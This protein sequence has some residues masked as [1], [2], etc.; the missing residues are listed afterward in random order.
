MR[1]GYD[2]NTRF[3]SSADSTEEEGRG[4]FRRRRKP[5]RLILLVFLAGLLWGLENRFQGLRLRNLEIRPPG[6]IPE[7]FLW[8]SI[9]PR[10]VRFWP[11]LLLEEDRL[12]REIQAY[13]PV[14][15]EFRLTGFGR[16]EVR[17]EPM[18][19]EVL[20]RWRRAY[21]YV[22]SEGRIWRANLPANAHIPGLRPPKGP[23]ILWPDS[24]P[25]LI[26]FGRLAG[27][28]VDSAF[29]VAA[30]RRWMS[31][32]SSMGWRERTKSIRIKKI[33]GRN[34]V[35][36]DLAVSGGETVV[37]LD[38]DPGRWGVT[39]RAVDAIARRIPG[40]LA[41]LWV[42]TTYRDKIIVRSADRKPTA[43]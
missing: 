19:P 24:G 32:L 7:D 31:G 40:G 3:A 29:P 12:T 33:E 9:P 11:F 27:D 41:G 37:V 39:A 36:V 14:R 20:L 1:S 42:D 8:E 21:W 43:P 35:V 26:E 23:L 6:T 18:S 5:G 15:A 25:P 22:S 30:A 38:E 28:V 2:S 16:F 17:L 10:A 4:R 34:A 13:Y